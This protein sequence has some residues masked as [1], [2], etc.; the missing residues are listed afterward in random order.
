[1]ALALLLF[2]VVS[3]AITT[4]L[5]LAE[6]Y[7]ND[8]PYIGDL[9]QRLGFVWILPAVL[10]PLLLSFAAF[11]LLYW[12]VP[13]GHRHPREVWHGALLAAAVFEVTKSLFGIY[14]QNFSNYDV[15]FGSLGAVAA[16]L[17]AVYVSAG[18][19]LFGAEVAAEYPKLGA[20]PALVRLP[21]I[22][23][24]KQPAWH[25]RARGWLSSLFGGH[26]ASGAPRP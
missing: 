16:F 6:R 10:L 21:S 20:E 25:R 19:M 5:R 24:A 13:A 22:P 8:I 23:Q 11:L 4:V 12:L 2:F 26:G 14:L 17:F 9:A 18:I 15:V 1:M 7:S 3:F